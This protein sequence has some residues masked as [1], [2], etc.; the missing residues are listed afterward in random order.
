MI[1]KSIWA[2]EFLAQRAAAAMDSQADESRPAKRFR[3]SYPRT[4]GRKYSRRSTIYRGPRSTTTT[5][6]QQYSKPDIQLLNTNQHFAWFFRIADLGNS[7]S[8]QAIYDEYRV[9]KWEISFTPMTMPVQFGAGSSTAA[10]TIPPLYTVID[11]DDANA[12]TTED[13][14]LQYDTL[15]I[16]QMGRTLSRKFIPALGSAVYAGAVTTG[17]SAKRKQ[18]IGTSQN[19]EH[20]G[21]KTFVPSSPFIG[22]GVP[23]YRVICRV[24]LQ[25]RNTK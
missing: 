18:L 15:R 7:A 19:V 9:M 16:A 23:L 20:Y 13:A 10:A 21:L 4:G 24:W 12:L 8:F 11:Y 14:Y 3:R 1:I 5:I 2:R 25:F 6:V 17:Y 22:A